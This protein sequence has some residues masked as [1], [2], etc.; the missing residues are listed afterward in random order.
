MANLAEPAIFIYLQLPLLCSF[1]MPVFSA[2]VVSSVMFYDL[3]FLNG[4]SAAYNLFIYLF[5]HVL[6][7]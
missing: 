1:W 2:N 7:K 3:R 4:D 5:I 6:L